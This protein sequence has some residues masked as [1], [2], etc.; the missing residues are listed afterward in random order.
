MMNMP[1]PDGLLN[2]R[3]CEQSKPLT[4]MESFVKNGRTYY[5][6]RCKKCKVALQL[7]YYRSP[8]GQR[9]AQRRGAKR[10]AQRAAN[11]NTARFIVEDTRATDRRH[12]YANDLTRELVES[13]IADGCA[14]C[15][16]TALRMTLDRIDN[17]RGHTHDNVVPACIRCNYTR[18]DMPYAAWLV[19]AAGMRQAREANLF[20]PW[21]GRVR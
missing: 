8:A 12:D 7:T 13:L 5:R 14:Y 19:V 18:K 10:K 1:T 11:L 4:E 6:R 21:T 16:E 9:T 17:A 15:G 20:G 3:L 2:C